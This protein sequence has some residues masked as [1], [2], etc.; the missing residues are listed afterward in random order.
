MQKLLII[1]LMCAIFINCRE[2]VKIYTCEKTDT[3]ICTSGFGIYANG[4][5]IN[6]EF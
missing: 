2:Y 5:P 1:L 3:K 4:G 6:H